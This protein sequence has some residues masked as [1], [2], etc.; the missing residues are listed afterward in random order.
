MIIRKARFFY[1]FFKT[2]FYGLDME[3]EP[4]PGPGPELS[5]VGTGT[6]INSYDFSTLLNTPKNVGFKLIFF[7]WHCPF[8]L[9]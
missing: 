7:S 9:L 6:V 2:A 4:E 3:P 1:N 5:K 8:N